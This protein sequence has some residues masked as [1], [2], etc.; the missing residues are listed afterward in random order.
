MILERHLA[1]AGEGVKEACPG[2]T[3]NT[4][5]KEVA[6]SNPTATSNKESLIPYFSNV[7]IYCTQE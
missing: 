5:Q 4:S 7:S 3:G 1:M 6:G 2:M